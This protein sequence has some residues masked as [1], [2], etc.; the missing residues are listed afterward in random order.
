MGT[1][2]TNSNVAW[3]LQ[4]LDTG[5][6]E[7]DCPSKREDV[8]RRFQSFEKGCRKE[9]ARRGDDEF[10]NCV[11]LG[12][13][14]GQ[15][16]SAEGQAI[17]SEEV[18]ARTMPDVIQKVLF[19]R[20]GWMRDYDGWKPDDRRP[21]G[22]GS[23]NKKK[24]GTERYNF[25]KCG[26][27]FYGF[28]QTQV[29]SGKIKL[30]RIA[31]GVLSDSIAGV[32]L[33]FVARRHGN[34]KQVVVGWYRNATLYRHPQKSFSARRNGLHYF[35]V[36]KIR[37]AVRLPVDMRMWKI[38]AGNKNT[39]GKTN[40]FYLYEPNGSRKKINWPGRILK[41]I[42]NCPFRNKW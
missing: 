1:K 17:A 40:V 33:I 19:S 7:K 29:R 9:V 34:G 22:G 31:P 39:M 36:S 24:P 13:D 15:G 12:E 30:E 20:I 6:H 28:V 26:R 35:A 3:Q 41:L 23:Y 10:R 16:S 37:D 21:I 8:A 5:G 38:P 25:Q 11:G 42:A 2:G 4:N 18:A 27:R 14:F 32:L